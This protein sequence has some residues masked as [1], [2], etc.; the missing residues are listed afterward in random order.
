MQN[1]LQEI[2]TQSD[3]I[4]GELCRIFDIARTILDAVNN[5]DEGACIL[6][7]LEILVNSIEKTLIKQEELGQNIFEIKLSKMTK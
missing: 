1:E 7:V 5:K 6:P 2:Y 4:E 3:E